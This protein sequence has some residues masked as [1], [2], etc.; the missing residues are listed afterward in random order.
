MPAAKKTSLPTAKLECLNPHS[1]AILHIDRK[2]YE[3]F[4]AAIKTSLKK[5]PGLSYTELVKAVEK[6]IHENKAMFT[7]SV[8]WY[9]VCVKND[10]EARAVLETWI[11]KGKKRQRLTGK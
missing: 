9:T 10:L 3:L 11:E 7:G 5:S 4:S 8:G 6:N 2:I 1:S